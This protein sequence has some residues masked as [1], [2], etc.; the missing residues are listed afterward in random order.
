MENEQKN[1]A[2]DQKNNLGAGAPNASIN[3][4]ATSNQNKGDNP[5]GGISANLGNSS[6]NKGKE[7]KK[8]SEGL[9]GKRV[10]SKADSGDATKK[11]NSKTPTPTATAKPDANAE[12]KNKPTAK[13][14]NKPASASA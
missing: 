14:N 13:S 5:S 4:T 7:D 1:Q 6:E 3:A 2:E 8:E 9:F 10:E 11:A 12:S